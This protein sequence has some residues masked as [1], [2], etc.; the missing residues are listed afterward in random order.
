MSSTAQVCA[1]LAIVM[2]G[3]SL[4]QADDEIVRLLES[5]DAA[6]VDRAA[7]MIRQMLAKEPARA[8]DR[9]NEGW[10]ASLL[11]A[12]KNDAVDEF[13]TTG[14]LALPADTW[15]IEQ[16]QKHRIAAL[17]ALK[18]PD[19][20]AKAAHSLFN[21]CGMGFVK[22]ALALVVDSVAA[23]RPHDHSV[24]NLLKTQ[25]LA[26]SQE[27]AGERE[28]LMKKWEG[29]S[30]LDSFVP[31]PGPYTRFIENARNVQGYRGLCGLG[32]LMLMSGRVNEAREV[33]L[34]ARAVAPPEEHTHV[35][36]SDARL[37]KAEDGGVGRANQYVHS[38]TE[39][40]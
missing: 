26:A 17:I 7:S 12:G 5:T 37:M 19:D 29:K 14:T 8:V 1:L 31:D 24:L 27:S 6:S 32:N 33:F 3:M 25:V 21:V 11:K 34:R 39:H 9:L 20:A 10:M 38:L 36:E 4:A 23:A 2:S 28:R 13:A 15:R 22:E 35:L 30:V 16:L 18:R 40:P